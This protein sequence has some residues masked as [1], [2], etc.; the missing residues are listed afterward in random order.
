MKRQIRQ[1]CFET[2]SSSTH[3]ICIA[4]EDMLDIPK[5][6]HFGFND[7][8][9]ERD[10]HSSLRAKANYLYTCLPY[11]AKDYNDLIEYVTFIYNTLKSHGV[12]NITMDNF[13]IGISTWSN[14]NFY[15]Q[16]ANDCYVDHGSNAD[17]F[18]KA[19]CTDENKLL[20]YLFSK[21]SYVE[22][23]NDNDDYDVDIKVDYPHE[24]YYK[25][26]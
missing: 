15:I 1:S 5:D 23:G 25:W 24:E 6:I 19:V 18:V 16:P 26:N 12:E 20:H 7:F 13:E 10:T 22:T 9:W 14:I 17:E 8:G 21:K 4:T 3:A 11:V 2:N